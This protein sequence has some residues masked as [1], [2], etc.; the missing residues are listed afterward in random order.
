MMNGFVKRV[1]GLMVRKSGFLAQPPRWFREALGVEMTHAGVEVSPDTA[2]TS[3]TVAACVRLLSE[4]IASL[5]LFVLRRTGESKLKAP[6]HPAYRLLHDRPNVYQTS[7]TW[8]QTAMS[9]VLLHGN[10]YALIERG[11]NGEPLALWPLDPA[12][13]LVRAEGGEIRYEVPGPLKLIVP[14]A[15]MLHFKGPS[16]NGIT[17]ESIISMARQGIGL[18]LALGQHGASLFKN[19]ARPGL[20]LKTQGRLSE[21]VRASTEEWLKRFSG[22]LNSGK[23][24]LLEGGFDVERPG[25]SN[26]DSEYILSRNFTVQEVARWFRIP[27]HMIGDPTRLA[28]AS[29]ESEMN[30]FLTHTL[31]PWLVN[32]EAEINFKLFGD[33]PQHF[34]E[35]DSNGV[36][37]G[38]QAARYS[39]Y[40]TGLNSGFLTVADVRR[41]ENLPEIP[42][43]DQL[44]PPASARGVMKSVVR[45]AEGRI[46]GV[47]EG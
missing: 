17:G 23:T 16:L 30:A 43:T 27:P 22:S 7:Y 29:S 40:E 8:R 47:V 19:G 31:R 26:Q 28:Y 10:A 45:D 38:D 33:D 5:P 12:R 15:D 3:A 25:Y 42:G 35:F 4:S 14:F 11:A 9:Q 36:A 24:V 44:L 34:A 1:A 18:D 32:L 20:I 39:A 37:R 21:S 2:M 46:A 41:W 13:V 6:E